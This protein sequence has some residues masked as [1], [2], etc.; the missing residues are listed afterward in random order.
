MTSPHPAPITAEDLR[1]LRETVRLSREHMLAGHGGPFGSLVVAQGT[2]LAEG[3]NEVTSTC[4][5]TAHAEVVAI[6]RA[7]QKLGHY[8]LKGTVLYASCE[9]CPMCLAAA[10]WARVERIV[11]A[12]SREDAA[13]GGFDDE[14]LYLEIPKTFETR[15]LP[16]QQ[17]LREEGAAVFEE[18][19]RMPDRTPY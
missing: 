6:R 3:W 11:F 16:M 7:C 17:C 12:A 9:P 15:T 2:V 14:F 10:Y 4:D 5:P 1:F 18:W 8:S 19:L 13:A